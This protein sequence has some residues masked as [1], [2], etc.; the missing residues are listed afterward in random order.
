MYK[1]I[2]NPETNRRVKING[3]IGRKVLLR[4]LHFIHQLGGNDN[5]PP[6]PPPPLSFS[7][8]SQP[9][10]KREKYEPNFPKLLEEFYQTGFP[11]TPLI[12][13]DYNPKYDKLI[14][15]S[16]DE[17]T[18]LTRKQLS[19][20]YRIN[21]GVFFYQSPKNIQQLLT[22]QEDITQE[23]ILDFFS[24]FAIFRVLLL[25]SVNVSKEKFSYYRYFP[26]N[27]IFVKIRKNP[28]ILLEYVKI[29]IKQCSNSEWFIYTQQKYKKGDISPIDKNIYEKINKNIHNFIDTMDRIFEIIS[30][31]NVYKN[32]NILFLTNRDLY[33]GHIFVNI[34][35]KEVY[36]VEC[37]IMM[38]VTKSILQQYSSCKSKNLSR[39]FLDK[40]ITYIETTLINNG[41]YFIWTYPLTGAGNKLVSNF[42]FTLVKPGDGI[43]NKPE[44]RIIYDFDNWFFI[45]TLLTENNQPTLLE[46]MEA[47]PI[48]CKW[49]SPKIQNNAL[50][51]I[52]NDTLYIKT[53]EDMKEYIKV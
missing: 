32:K 53:K 4:Y 3:K 27:N 17:L 46:N 7:P 41:I 37:S 20:K 13:E 28:N 22:I 15:K 40:I 35:Q 33:I 2:I 31:E 6:P 8:I 9:Q 50:E 51:S 18:S 10:S 23:D 25:L 38:G 26:N 36:N 16:I 52:H 11:S 47:F 12:Y 45:N 19:Y 5:I 30:M 48:V 43:P 21:T 24:Y 49:L 44:N 1:F 39:G 29:F 34:Y 14:F 42:G